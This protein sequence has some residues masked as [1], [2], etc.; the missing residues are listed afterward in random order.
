MQNCVSCPWCSYIVTPVVSTHYV[1][2]ILKEGKQTCLR[3][4]YDRLT[5]PP[6]EED[7]DIALHKSVCMSVCNIFVSD[8]IN[9]RM[10]WPTSLLNSSRP[11]RAA[12]EPYW[13]W[14]HWIKGQGHQVKCVKTVSDCWTNNF[15]KWVSSSYILCNLS[16]TDLSS[17]TKKKLVMGHNV[18]QI[19][20]LKVHGHIS[21]E[22]AGPY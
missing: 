2:L 4:R 16:W 7:R 15:P 17:L 22:S 14:G 12:E 9:S 21:A 20:V 8:Q 6:F 11:S 5:M 13:F 10:P 18:L 1:R 19:L 3:V